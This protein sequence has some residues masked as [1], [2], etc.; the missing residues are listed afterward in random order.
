MLEYEAIYGR[1]NFA[2]LKPEYTLSKK[3]RRLATKIKKW[4]KV[5][6]CTVVLHTWEGTEGI[7]KMTKQ[8]SELPKQQ[9]AWLQSHMLHPWHS[10]T[11]RETVFQR[12]R[13][14]ERETNRRANAPHT[15]IV[16]MCLT[17][18]ADTPSLCVYSK[19]CIYS[20]IRATQ[21]RKGIWR[22]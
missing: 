13:Q 5:G 1:Y 19:P 6:E 21:T 7:Q 4:K 16:P 9:S 2:N 11:L 20:V 12:D 22:E 14:T 3:K 10:T 15:V 8:S 18:S 17:V